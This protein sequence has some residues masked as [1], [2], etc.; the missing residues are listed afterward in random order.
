MIVVNEC[1]YTYQRKVGR[2][3]K[4]K[5]D[6]ESVSE[7]L[8]S[9]GSTIKRVASKSRTRSIR[10][11]LFL[12]V[13]LIQLLLIIISA[14]SLSLNYGSLDA[15]QKLVTPIDILAVCVLITANGIGFLAFVSSN[16]NLAITYIVFNLIHVMAVS[17][18]IYFI[19]EKTHA[20]M[21]SFLLSIV[22]AI[23]TTCLIA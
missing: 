22:N 7:E 9:K 16:V 13:L 10:S 21:I 23:V 14:I 4:E 20:Q 5:M 17:L 2:Q 11:R 6:E 19:D 18:S 3:E 8:T 12:I 15:Y 1:V